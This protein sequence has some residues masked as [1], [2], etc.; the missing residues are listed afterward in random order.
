MA[1]ANELTLNG[2][3][4]YHDSDGT[5]ISIDIANLAASVSAK[6]ALH[7]RQNIGVTEEAIVLGEVTA[8]GW[9]FA[10]NRDPT[11]FIEC[12]VA[13]GGA[14]FA[15]MKPGEFCMLRLGSGAQAPYA[16]ADTGACMM[17][18]AVAY[19]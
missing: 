12:R 14:K 16:I 17:E 4:E 2:S 13:T 3:L 11:N 19:N 15:K 8:P 18:Y 1:M 10:I 5:E 9:F 6:I 7:A